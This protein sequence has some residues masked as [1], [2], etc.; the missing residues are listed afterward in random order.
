M[1]SCVVAIVVPD[2]EII[3]RWANHNGI[4]GTLS[5][6]CNNSDVKALILADMLELG[7]QTGLKSFEQVIILD[8][9]IW[10]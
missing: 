8:A 1:Q 3:K 5:V 4:A 7:K 10:N 6:L 9:F 2:V